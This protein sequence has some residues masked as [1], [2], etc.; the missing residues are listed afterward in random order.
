MNH[1]KMMSR[2]ADVHIHAELKS[3]RS[4]AEL[5]CAISLCRVSRDL[6]IEPTVHL[7]AVT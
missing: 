7:E 4:C 5:I 3:S 6:K 2:D 1:V